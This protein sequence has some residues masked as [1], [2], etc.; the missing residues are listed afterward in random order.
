MF[1]NS[2]K[3]LSNRLLI[4]GF[5]AL[6]LVCLG[7]QRLPAQNA[8][9]ISNSSLSSQ[10]QESSTE[11]RISQGRFIK[12]NEKRLTFDGRVKSDPVILEKGNALIYTS[13]EKFN[14]LCLMKLE[15]NALQE[16]KAKPQRFHPSANTSELTVSF[17]N[18]E[19]Q[20]VYLRNNG[21][22]HFEIVLEDLE[23]GE[24]IKHNPGGGFA[25]VRNVAYH[26]NGS[27]VIF[28][29]P[30]QNGPQQIWTMSSQ[31]G[32]VAL[33]TNSEG[34]NRCPKFSADGKKIVFSSSRDGDFDI[35]VMKADGS[36][37][38]NVSST[39][40]LDTHPAFS[41][42]GREIAF[43]GL[44]KGN[45]DIYIMNVDGSNL[46]RLTDNEEVD[47]YPVWAADGK[48]LYWVGERAGKRDIYQK[49]F[50]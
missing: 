25:G 47:D 6:W 34:I 19:K 8:R 1:L 18:N 35:F 27:Q 15:L 10:D 39:Q 50:R 37:P 13:L 24:T 38:V 30:D 14:Q 12:G 31:G 36:S 41:P 21:N 48:S 28:A 45:Y 23:T 20:Y 43:T 3:S 40:G 2:K 11:N 9:P 33:L 49:S 44:R 17:A 7:Q 5:F 29:F 22:L 16:R 46:R 4:R 32:K 26:P 42:N